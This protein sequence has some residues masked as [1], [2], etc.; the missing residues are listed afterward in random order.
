MLSVADALKIV[1]RT[2]ETVAGRAIALSPAALGLVLAEDVASDLDMPPFDKAM[3]DG[4]ARAQRRSAR[5]AG[6]IGDRRGNCRRARRRERLRRGPGVAH[7]DRGADSARGRR[8]RDDRT[9]RNRRRP[10]CASMSRSVKPGLNILRKG[11]EMRHGETVL[12][13]G[14]RCGLRS[15]A[16]WRRSGA[17]DGRGAAGAAWWR[18]SP[19]AMNW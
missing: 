9:L 1:L 19:P 13:A 7:H 17:N 4:F 8:G 12:P 16:C 5:R 14:A 2:G 6:R 3:M 11:R 15:S 10:V 18:C